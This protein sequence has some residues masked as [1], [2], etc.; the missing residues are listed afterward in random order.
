VGFADSVAATR[1]ENGDRYLG[2]DALVAFR[3]IFSRG[4]RPPSNQNDP[5]QS[6]TEQKSQQAGTAARRQIHG[7]NESEDA[8][9]QRQSCRP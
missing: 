9:M 7:A 3:I 4:C 2:R 1:G 8:G 6:Q 5:N